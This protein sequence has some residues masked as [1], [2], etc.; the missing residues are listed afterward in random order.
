[1]FFHTA[2]HGQLT[3]DGIPL[4]T[5]AWRI[6][7]LQILDSAGDTRGSDVPIPHVAGVKARPRRITAT[8]R[9]LEMLIQ[10]EVNHAGVAYAN[11]MQGKKSNVRYLRYYVVRPPA[12]TDG[13]RTAILTDADGAT[14]SR[15]VHVTG[16]EVGEAP[17]FGKVRA[18]LDISIPLGEF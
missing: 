11:A 2:D 3:I 18:T 6:T 7:N 10:G 1:M 12:T 15:P 8:E 5:P 4:M 13:T 16:F 17:G 9:T 14:T